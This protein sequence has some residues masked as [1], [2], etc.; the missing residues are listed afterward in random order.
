MASRSPSPLSPSDAVDLEPLR[1]PVQGDNGLDPAATHITALIRWPLA[2]TH[3]WHLKNPGCTLLEKS[4][5]LPSIPVN[6]FATTLL[7]TTGALLE[8]KTRRKKLFRLELIGEATM[9][10]CPVHRLRQS[11]P[12]HPWSQENL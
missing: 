2:M 9:P 12:R 4:W 5:L 1:L 3:L 11:Y 7:S 8:T 10:I 6:L